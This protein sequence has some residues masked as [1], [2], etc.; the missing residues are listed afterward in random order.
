[1]FG[2]I[3]V[4][5]IPGDHISVPSHPSAYLIQVVGTWEKVVEQCI[6]DRLQPL[7]LFYQAQ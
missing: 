3:L 5:S 1:M 2:I 4:R 6:N 7:V